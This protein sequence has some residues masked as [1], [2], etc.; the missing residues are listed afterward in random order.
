MRRSWPRVCIVGS[1]DLSGPHDDVT[2]VNARP[3]AALRSLEADVLISLEGQVVHVEIEVVVVTAAFEDAQDLD[4]WA[5]PGF[6]KCQAST[7]FKGCFLHD[8][9][10]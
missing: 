9:R 1:A 3:I 5:V 8:E 4:T 10:L 7:L 6:H 2:T